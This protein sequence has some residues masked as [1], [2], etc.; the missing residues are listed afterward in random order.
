VKADKTLFV[1]AGGFLVKKPGRNEE[2]FKGHR[3]A[4]GTSLPRLLA[5]SFGF[6]MLT[7]GLLSRPSVS[8]RQWKVRKIIMAKLRRWTDI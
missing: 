3:G 6:Q 5:Q 4:L 7:F 2:N 1:V 8:P